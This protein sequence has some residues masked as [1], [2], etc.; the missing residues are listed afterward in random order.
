MRDKLVHLP[1]TQKTLDA[2]KVRIDRVNKHNDQKLS[3]Q[4]RD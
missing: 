1:K 3:P 4:G 2:K